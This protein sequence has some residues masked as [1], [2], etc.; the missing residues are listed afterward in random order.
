MH[1]SQVYS[2]HSF[3][4][5]LKRM[6]GIHRKKFDHSHLDLLSSLRIWSR[7]FGTSITWNLVEAQRWSKS[8]FILHPC[9]PHSVTLFSLIYWFLLH[10]IIIFTIIKNK[11][12]ELR[13][14][15]RKE[16]KSLLY[17]FTWRLGG[18]ICVPKTMK[19]RPCMFVSQTSPVGVELFSYVNAFFRSNKFA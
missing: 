19:R 7:V 18:H 13:R 17:V 10:S 6:N 12:A 9:R 16:R 11:S 5:P 3:G 1:A 15:G 4:L 8:V 14:K 2:Q